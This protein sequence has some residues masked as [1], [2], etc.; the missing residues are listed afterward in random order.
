MS[1]HILS[2]ILDAA[3][4]VS[5]A[6]ADTAQTAQGPRRI[7]RAAGWD[8]DAIVGFPVDS[9]SAALQQIDTNLRTLAEA[10]DPDTIIE[11]AQKLDAI[12]EIITA[13]RTL[14]DAIDGVNGF[15]GPSELQTLGT[16]LLHAIPAQIAAFQSPEFTR[17]AILL[18]ILKLETVTPVVSGGQYLRFPDRIPRWNLAQIGNLLSDPV[19]TL[20]TEYGAQNGLPDQATADSVADSLFPRLAAFLNVLGLQATYGTNASYAFDFG[21]EGN[22]IAARC[23]TV[24]APDIQ[25]VGSQAAFGVTLSLDSIL[26]VVVRPLAEGVFEKSLGAWSTSVEIAGNVGAVAIDN[27]SITFLPGAT[28]ARFSLDAIRQLTVDEISGSEVVPALVL[29]TPTASRIEIGQFGLGVDVGLSSQQ[30]SYGFELRA[31]LSELI[32]SS[33][34]GDGLL[35]EVAPA[36]SRVAFEL[37]FGWSSDRGLHFKGSSSLDTSYSLNLDI[38]GVVK[39]EAIHL[40]IGASSSGQA[41]VDVGLSLRFVL[42]PVQV[43]LIGTGVK[44]DLDFATTSG[45]LGLFDAKPAFLPPTGA[46]IS[47]NSGPVSGGGFLTFD[48]DNGRYAGAVSLRIYDIDLS[49]FGVIDTKLPNGQSGFSMAILISA[50]FTPIQLGLG[51]TLNGVGGLLG[52]HRSVNIEFLQDSVRQGTLDH[53]LFPDR[54]EENALEILQSLQK[55]FPA[56]KDRFAIAPMAIIGWGGSIPIMEAE[57]GVILELPQPSRVTAIGQ[58]KVGLPKLDDKALVKLN[59]DTVG[60]LDFSAK[61]LALDA[62]LY[63]SKVG[64]F[65]VSGDMAFRLKWSDPPNFTLAIGG[66]HPRFKPPT[67]FPALE[68]VRVD[69]G[70]DGNPR[71]TLQGY[72][73]V[74]SNTVQIGASA[75]ALATRGKYSVYGIIG[76]DG[77]F[78]FEPFAFVVDF[79]VGAALRRNGKRIAGIT[80]KGTLS[81][82]NPW[83]A[84]GRACISILFFDLCIGFEAELSRRKPIAASAIPNLADLVKTHLGNV[85]NWEAVA[86]SNSPK[87]ISLADNAS[88]KTL[89]DPLGSL[90]V[91]QR[92]LPLDRQIEM[93]R[94]IAIPP[95]TLSLGSTA[96]LV[97]VN[98]QP[99]QVQLSRVT[100]YFAPGQF[101]KQSDADKLSSESFVRLTGGATVTGAE[102]VASKG[103]VESVAI[104]YETTIIEPQGQ[105]SQSGYGIAPQRSRQLFS[106]S[107]AATGG[108]KNVGTAKFRNLVKQ[109]LTNSNGGGLFTITSKVD[110]AE[111]TSL[112]ASYLDGRTGVSRAEASQV[113]R[114]IAETDPIGSR[115]LQVSSTETLAA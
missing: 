101:F 80:L 107:L 19:G 93:Y 57:L 114:R 53:V 29:G 98:G 74:T 83:F 30:R 40:A 6:M 97:D 75:E 27:D 39:V 20:K 73:A 89:F 28:E 24:R 84:K 79:R 65:P 23:L 15:V 35:Q 111:Q 115:G 78:Q 1:K 33:R 8:L 92:I 81:G 70:K 113:L 109:L 52:I 47:I 82:P 69:L 104:E 62:R 26:G 112:I 105:S 99:F 48:Y 100:E 7:L 61:T 108:L 90:T 86:P 3:S 88:E 49:A 25:R 77:L 31:G 2:E 58:I 14:H 55:A 42:G 94:M 46:G 76:F 72:L 67:G 18:G 106:R 36:E 63:D 110:L 103:Q 4:A 41:S 51:F 37:A 91:R 54:P 5:S 102:G 21:T 68:R 50:H 87:V 95:Q 60:V 44:A 17:L 71:I 45:N 43:S 96:E 34:E 11:L 32:L 13:I 16:D 59:L 22:R 66:F 10:G 64:G 38:G 85:A 56:A 12:G 9:L